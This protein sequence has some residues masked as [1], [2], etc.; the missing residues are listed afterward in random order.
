MKR[1]I[2]IL[3]IN[4]IVLTIK[5]TTVVSWSLPSSGYHE[6]YKESKT[7]VA[8]KGDVIE[9]KC[10]VSLSAGSKLS[11][12][13]DGVELYNEQSYMFSEDGTYEVSYEYFRAG[14]GYA[15]G[16]DIYITLTPAEEFKL[17]EG[18]QIVVDYFR[19][20]YN[21]QSL[22]LTKT[23][24][25]TS[26][27]I[28]PNYVS[29]KGQSYNVTSIEALVFWRNTS[30]K[31]V[32]IPNTVTKIG[33]SLFLGCTSLKKVVLSTKIKEIPD[34]CFS[35]CSNL[36][37]INIPPSVNRIGSMAFEE[38]ALKKLI[39]PNSLEEIDD[40]AFDDI[41]LDTIIIPNSVKAIGAYAFG[42]C[43]TINKLVLGNG[44]E[45][46]GEYAFNACD[47]IGSVTIG[48]SLHGE[49]S[50]LF[51]DEH[52]SNPINVDEL[53]F[54][55]GCTETIPTVFNT[56]KKIKIPNTVIEISNK[57]F[58]NFNNVTEI[59]LPNTLKYI[60]DYA[61]NGCSKLTTINIPNELEYL[62]QNAFN[63]CSNLSSTITIPNKCSKVSEYAFSSCKRIQNV[64]ICQG[65]KDIEQC[66]FEDCSQ[67]KNLILDE[68]IENIKEHAFEN[69]GIENDLIL[70]NSLIS[71]GDRA[72][73]NCKN[74][75]SITFG[76]NL[77]TIGEDAFWG[78]KNIPTITFGNNL[79][80]IGAGAFAGCSKLRYLEVP[81]N[82]KSIGEYAFAGLDSLNH[83]EIGNNITELNNVFERDIIKKIII[84]SKINKLTDGTSVFGWDDEYGNPLCYLLTNNTVELSAGKYPR[85]TCTIYVADSTKYSTN[86]IRDYQIRNIVYS[87]SCEVEY[88]GK[89]PNIDFASHLEG[90][91]ATIDTSCFNVGT[92]TS[93]A[94][95]FTNG[96]FH[97][98]INVPCNY[99][100][101]KAPLK[102]IADDI[103]IHY[104]DTIPSLD[105]SY[106]GFKNNETADN[107][108]STKPTITT[109]AKKGSNVGTYTISIGGAEAQNYDITYQ[110]A[111]LVINKAKQTITWN[112]EFTNIT[113]GSKIELTA[114]TS[115][116]LP[117]TYSSSDVKKAIITNE[118][119]KYY[120]Y[121][122]ETGTIS[123]I[124]TQQGDNNHEAATSVTKLANITPQKVT[125][126]K[127]SN[128]NVEITIGHIFSLSATVLP[129]TAINK[130]VTWSSS[131]ESV[132]KVNNGI[133][134]AIGIGEAYIS[135][136][137]TDDSN[138]T[139]KCHVTVKPVYVTSI[140]F[141]ASSYEIEVGSTQTIT[142]SILPKNATYKELEWNSSNTNVATVEN[143]IVK[144]LSSGT[145][146]ITAKA[147][148]GGNVYTNC[149]IRVY[150]PV[151]DVTISKNTL[152]LLVND[153]TTLTAVCTPSNA[154]NTAI[155][156]SSDNEEV[157]T[158]SQ[159]GTV[160]AKSAGIA[161]ITATTTDGSNISASCKVTIKKH[162]QS[163]VWEQSLDG[164]AVGGSVIEVNA[165]TSSG[166]PVSYYSSADERIVNFVSINGKLY[167]NPVSQGTTSVTARFT[168][169]NYYADT[170]LT[171]TVT[172]KEG[173]KSTI[174]FD[175]NGGSSVMS[176]TA[177]CGAQIDC[178][179]S[180]ER[181]G[182]TFMGWKPAF[183]ATMPYED[184]TLTA[185]W[186]PKKYKVTF[187][188]DGNVMQE[189]T[190]DYGTEIIL[191]T[192]EPKK[193]GYS[194]TGW[195]PAVDATIP[196]HDVTYN[197]VFKR[198][199][200]K[201]TFDTD[202]GSVVEAIEG[203]Y[204]SEYAQPQQ[205]VKTGYSFAGWQPSIPER[206]PAEDMSVKALWKLNRPQ[207]D[208][209]ETK[210]DYTGY[211]VSLISEAS[212]TKMYYSTDGSEPTSAS[213]LYTT[214]I[215]INNDVTIKA[216][217]IDKNNSKSEVAR[218]AFSVIKM[219]K[220]Q[221]GE[222]WNWVTINAN[223]KQS[224]ISDILSVGEWT[225]GDEVKND[226]KAISFSEDK[227]KWYGTLGVGTFDNNK[228]YKIHSA[229]SQVLTTNINAA[230]PEKVEISVMP[231]WNYIAYPLA[232]TEML[233]EALANYDAEDGD[234]IKSQEQFSVYDAKTA[235][236]Q[237]ELKALTSGRGYMIKR[238]EGA[239]N[240]KFRFM[241]STG[242]TENEET[243][244]SSKYANNMNLIAT[245]SGLPIENGDSIVAVCNNEIRGC[246]SIQTDSKAYLTIQGN[247]NDI[248]TM[249][250]MRNGNVV[251]YANSSIQYAD[252][253]VVGT[254]DNPTSI[255]FNKYDNG[256]GTI[257]AIYDTNGR[258]MKT[259]DIDTLPLGTYLIH[260]ILKG[261]SK[262]TKINKR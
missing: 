234:I 246:A 29:F 123:I 204:D 185:Q 94:V 58:Y 56:T 14:G 106:I 154:D 153:Q 27:V 200:H 28:I 244:R 53:I 15:Y 108:I 87:K 24:K 229:K 131:N 190:L 82:V 59:T 143:G 113:S 9:C 43:H 177:L 258:A 23:Y 209:N 70:P 248:M 110:N 92:Y 138:I 11:V 57:A 127:L 12:K 42:G 77:Q 88:T 100:I 34:H 250:L 52:T 105:C 247:K 155:Q 139:N 1:I 33:S 114:N 213:T 35:S 214:P 129:N 251:A 79:Q 206:I 225:L 238:K 235:T 149:S 18:S 224:A 160:T 66:A 260:S 141:D 60:G 72:F 236:W 30:L 198:E 178:P 75:P 86:D 80:T 61:F 203:L 223:G 122:L 227:K 222:G 183:P 17:E 196:S 130:N 220:I 167:L 172:V 243:V 51:Y 144:G 152:S 217:A 240:A 102:V 163:I 241:A 4:F 112:Q 239:R 142:T 55:E 44:L 245:I 166:L 121:P 226:S 78:C 173:Q 91:N 157:A 188:A 67:L 219:P 147:T 231:G 233:A 65:V 211:T 146:V 64:K 175:S 31:S 186:K 201:I 32:I 25:N 73:Y 101:T 158:V 76:N 171:R 104:G 174:T 159:D 39:L 49:L 107:A 46:I 71:V 98:R 162:P 187:M 176:I 99:I 63:G 254:V 2:F 150:Q 179:Q 230:N 197:A 249:R 54:A 26:D 84:G 210:A 118:D 97:S 19:Y 95:D 212:D 133:I 259:T 5:A 10:K 140:Y 169:N 148:D 116:G 194:F 151:K 181:N 195:E 36:V 145:S 37:D 13:V 232:T 253:T 21:G 89:M 120:L 3:I 182:Y 6:T 242:V 135:V 156:W 48:S 192:N 168:R 96:D 161:T 124:A 93:M 45:E 136:T 189:N 257:T 119:G 74:I 115:S 170:E 208:R 216:I 262:I 125:D 68:G 134:T 218:F 199:N 165:K 103:N 205:P 252:D 255:K 8:S 128:T 132:A 164:L 20:L 202:G 41:E 126:I 237:G 180:P 261:A 85:Q 16:G 40:Y 228:M 193:T 81:N 7:F 117:I 50:G 207:T 256:I 221:I 111:T 184:M 83:V 215:I 38:T 69:C 62:G 47:N 137:S 191:P 109:S 22:S 90:Y